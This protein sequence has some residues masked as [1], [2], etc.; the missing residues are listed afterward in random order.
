M[1]NFAP[2][3]APNSLWRATAG[4]APSIDTGPLPAHADVVVIGAGYTGLWTALHLLREQPGL[5]VVV[6]DRTSIGFGASGRNGG[7][8]SALFPT[9]LDRLA[10]HSSRGSAIDMQRAMFGIVDELD[11]WA[12]DEGID[13]DYAKGGTL[14]VARNVAQVHS[15]RADIEH[16]RAWGADDGDVRMLNRVETLDRI[17]AEGALAGKFTPH[18]AA[19]HPLKLAY[20]LAEATRRRG[21]V[22]LEQTAALSYSRGVVT[23]NRGVITCDAVIRA[24]EG[25]TARFDDH[26][27]EIMPIYSLMVATAPLT[28]AQW[29][30]IGL[31]ER[32]TFTEQ[33]HVVIY[34]QRTADGRL[35]FGGRGAPYHWGSSVDSRFDQHRS[36]H[37]GL[38]EAL[39]ELFPTLRST[40][41][42]H[43]W[44]GALGIPRDYTPFVR[45]A[46]GVGEA[47]GYVGD[48]VTSA[49]LAG[50][51]LA[52][53]VLGRNTARTALPWVNHRSR[54]WEP[55]PLRWL[56]ANGMLAGLSLAD[57]SEART[58]KP[59][60][61]AS[62]LYRFL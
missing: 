35:A 23:T 33:R 17:N 9:S 45:F 15:M 55:E 5:S 57:R 38:H 42:T 28:D 11:A 18:C 16:D 47:G 12:R 4:P 39:I 26:A 1:S 19:I 25:F 22:I 20:G 7:W 51:T 10:A 48:G 58:G 8:A 31:R 40:P 60:R 21:G 53:L 52:D 2:E 37:R 24:T 27:R 34:G 30:D 41:I 13:Y 14:T 61:L 54:N 62:A 46:D 43:R 29:S 36:V 3:R 56:E 59:S 6:L 44:G 49:A 50:R 32:E